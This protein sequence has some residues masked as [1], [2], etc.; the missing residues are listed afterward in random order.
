MEN[1]NNP[2]KE[3]EGVAQN[4]S[5]SND[6]LESTKTEQK[7][8][9]PVKKYVRPLVK[10]LHEKE[11]LK[12]LVEAIGYIDF[13]DVFHTNED[14]KEKVAELR[15]A[16][17]NEK[18]L[19]DQILLRNELKVY[20]PD[21]EDCYI[22]LIEEILRIADEVGLGIG[23]SEDG[24]FPYFYNG[25][26][27]EQM[28]KSLSREFI[29]EV[30]GNS[31]FGYYYTRKLKISDAL[32]KQF[33]LLQSISSKHEDN[34]V[35]INLLNGTFVIREDSRGL[36]SFDKSDF[37]K[38]QLSFD[39]D[40]DAKAP[41]FQ[42]FL[43][44]FLPERESQMILME[45][46]GYVFTNHLKMEKCL[47]LYGS[48]SNGKSVIFDIVAAL[49]GE[50]NICSY[51][52]SNLCTENGYFRAQLSNHLLNYS[53]ELGGRNTNADV[54]KKL[55]SNEPI[56][57][58]SPYSDPF[59]LRNYCKFLFNANTLPNQME[60]T[61]AYFRRFIILEFKEK[62][63]EEEMDVDFAKKIIKDELSGIFNMVLEGLD[64]ILINKKFTESKKAKEFL[65]NVKRENNNVAMFM[66]DMGYEK[67]TSPGILLKELRDRYYTYCQENNIHY[68]LGPKKFS[69]A[70]ESLGYTIVRKG[71]NNENRVLCGFRKTGIGK[72][73]E[74]IFGIS[75]EL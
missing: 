32:Y 9:K 56:D 41:K 75:P 60:N 62:V 23:T 8:V 47:V 34:V 19:K 53:S 39:Y 5:E 54:I 13:I 16:L 24:N 12:S 35:K 20:M 36:H 1:I 63:T 18:N 64:R 48:G 44:R 46:L 27:W 51:T 50:E 58:R 40:V 61:D 3:D 15:E 37:F 67:T 57:A 31:G 66:E 26:Y 6:A 73:I 65:E 4:G 2:E 42:A 21:T 30:G 7:A 74:D 43:D 14:T 70:I 45:Y 25:C 11:G 71:T 10:E 38:Y 33:V 59:I 69:E 17:K 49:L 22:M 28:S 29:M 52:L 72:E 55:I 68:R